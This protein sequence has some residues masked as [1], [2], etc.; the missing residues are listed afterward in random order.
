M[1]NDV[2]KNCF[3]YV[4]SYFFCQIQMKT[5]NSVN[6]SSYQIA[7]SSSTCSS[8]SS[9]T[10]IAVSKNECLTIENAVIKGY[11]VCNI[12]P[13]VWHPPT[14]LVV[15]RAY[16]QIHAWK[17]CVFCLGTSLGRL[18]LWHSLYVNRQKAPVK[19]RGQSWSTYIG[20]VSKLLSKF[21][22][23]IN[24]KWHIYAIWY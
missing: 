22:M 23:H 13:H 19:I 7:A 24:I 3:Y 4:Y 12:R 5:M 2:F 6:S 20:H 18:S 1:E 16:I 10:S 8:S 17:E 15:D 9:L 21:I 11:H 14:K